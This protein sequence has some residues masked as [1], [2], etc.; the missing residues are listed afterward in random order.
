MLATLLKDPSAKLDYTVDFG[1]WL[2]ESEQITT[3]TWARDPT[4]ITIGSASYA[5]SI[6]SDGKRCTVWLEGGTAGETYTITVS[7]TTNNSPAR[8]DQRSFY[9][10]VEDR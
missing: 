2:E 6:S 4:G 3:A 9:V 5:S 10:Q 7:V 1:G 8:L